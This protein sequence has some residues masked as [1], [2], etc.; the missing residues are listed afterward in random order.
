MDLQGAADETHLTGG[1]IRRSTMAD[2]SYPFET[3]SLDDDDTRTTHSKSSKGSEGAGKV[4]V[5]GAGTA[6]KTHMVVVEEDM[7]RGHVKGQAGT[8]LCIEV[9][10]KVEYHAKNKKE[11]PPEGAI[12]LKVPG[13]KYQ[14]FSEPVVSIGNLPK[15][16]TL[17]TLDTYKGSVEA[18]R[19]QMMTASSAPPKENLD[20]SEPWEAVST[21]D[22]PASAFEGA[23]GTWKKPRV[24]PGGLFLATA[25]RL[26][27]PAKMGT[28]FSRLNFTRDT[29]R[30]HL[31]DF[32]SDLESVLRSGDE[33]AGRG[34]EGEGPPA[35]ELNPSALTKIVDSLCSCADTIR[36]LEKGFNE[37][38][39]HIHESA[40][41]QD[42][43]FEEIERCDQIIAA[44]IGNKP[45]AF[46][47]S[48]VWE[49]IA[50][51]SEQIQDPYEGLDSP[52]SIGPGCGFGGNLPRHPGILVGMGRRFSPVPLAV[53]SVLPRNHSGMVLKFILSNELP[54][55]RRRNQ[56]QRI[57]L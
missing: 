45:D 56:T 38:M 12:F 50:T 44:R 31:E 34:G 7:C 2:D 9:D 24:N 18:L 25:R 51:I 23:R 21:F 22:S 35:R 49:G 33:E 27:T 47:G 55:T 8:K 13:R 37:A 52:S 40:Q 4:L 19:A 16:V 20:A 30:A 6:G 5:S 28:T 42:E 46:E 41:V 14:V 48:T 57:Q 15:G 39:A 1:I 53:A 3:Y 36:D 17:D 54:S 29:A 43:R 10:C 26:M 32:E 11:V